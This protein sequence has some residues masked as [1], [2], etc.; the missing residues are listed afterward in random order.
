M[1]QNH[2]VIFAELITSIDEILLADILPDRP[3]M[4]DKLERF[5]DLI[6]TPDFDMNMRDSSN[7]TL[8]AHIVCVMLGEEFLTKNAEAQS[9][10]QPI[11]VLF[12]SF[13][14][15]TFLSFFSGIVLTHSL[16]CS[17]RIHRQTSTATCI[18]LVFNR[19]QSRTN[20]STLPHQTN[21]IFI[22][23]SIQSSCDPTST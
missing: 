4:E 11:S 21:G 19:R 10:G 3:P 8:L 14:C 9:Y 22:N 20:L 1:E 12:C 17:S 16:N 5:A 7:N 2:A 15:P 23:A 18:F 13:I 6:Q